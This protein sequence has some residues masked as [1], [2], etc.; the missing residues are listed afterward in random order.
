[1]ALLSL[2]PKM[3]SQ[4]EKAIGVL[5]YTKMESVILFQRASCRH[6][7][8]DSPANKIICKCYH[9][10]EKSGC[11]RNHM[12]FSYVFAAVRLSDFF[13]WCFVKDNMYVVPLPHNLDDLKTCICN[14]QNLRTPDMLKR[15]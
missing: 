1:M 11:L 2:K 8:K 13:L 12:T 4:Q 3:T 14:A 10:F 9:K 6:F 15:V 5:Q 7:L